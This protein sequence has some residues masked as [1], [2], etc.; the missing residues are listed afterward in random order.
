MFVL[1]QFKGYREINTLQGQFLKVNNYKSG[2][3]VKRTVNSSE[4]EYVSE[5]STEITN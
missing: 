2:D 4:S 5:L 3:G 1:R